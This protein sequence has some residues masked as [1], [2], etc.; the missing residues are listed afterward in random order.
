[1]YARK[2]FTGLATAAMTVSA[3]TMAA[4]PAS[5]AY[6]PDPDDVVPTSTTDLLG[7]GS[8]TSQ[9]ALRRAAVAYNAT[10]PAVRLATYAA[11]GGGDVTLPGGAV[12]NPRPNGS[13][14]GKTLLY[15]AANQPDVD[16]ARSSSALNAT[17]VGAGLRAFPFAL[18]TLVMSV[19]GSTASN[20]PAGLTPQQI[21]QIYS[22]TVTNW[23]QVGGSPGV[24]A[25]K[26]PQPGS[27][28]RSFFTD[29][30]RAANGGTAVTLAPTVQ[31][32]QEHDPAP[33]QGNPNAVAPFSEGR[34]GLVP[35]TLRLQTGFRADRALYNV[36]RGPNVGDAAVVAAFGTNGYLCSAAARPQIEAA[37]FKQL[38]TPA[39]GGVCGQSTQDPTSNFTIA[40]VPT[41]T[42]VSVTSASA[43][44]ARVT[45]RISAGTAPS[46]TV[47]FFEGSTPVATNVP[48]QSGQAVATPAAAP[49][50]HTYRAVFTPAANTAFT[51]SEGVGSGT[52]SRAT[53]TLSES[54]A[55][56]AKTTKK[57]KKGKKTIVK[58]LKGTVSAALVGSA[59]RG[60]GTVTVT[61][62]SKT[63]GTATLAGGV[64]S[65]K[66]K[67]LK[68]GTNKL[69]ATWAGDANAS[70]D[71]VSFTVK[72]AKAKAKKKK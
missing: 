8:D 9:S 48:L 17:E 57:G 1:M 60:T 38:F 63:L 67:G 71:T 56:K 13:G 54:F 55:A 25:P 5:A 49:G 32:V 11:T 30:L 44:S 6:T 15:G 23:S 20:A 58:P 39:R 65:M 59:A 68:P 33:I 28:T 70:G 66:L 14:A 18:D 35:G 43:S 4:G 16:F 45:A 51:G 41:S 21:V 46:G 26:I 36:V 52:V 3:I 40:E 2:L 37:G 19:S 12:L 53:S 69:T 24:I 72:A 27:G 61:R 31:D 29:Q 7:F 10:N 62:G 50:A 34:A 64:A 47:S 22:G 42:A